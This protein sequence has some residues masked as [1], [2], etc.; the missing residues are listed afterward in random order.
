LTSVSCLC[1]VLNLTAKGKTINQKFLSL[2]LNT[3]LCNLITGNISDQKIVPLAFMI[4]ANM[5]T[6]DLADQIFEDCCLDMMKLVHETTL[7]KIRKDTKF[8]PKDKIFTKFFYLITFCRFNLN[9]LL[10]ENFIEKVQKKIPH[11]KYFEVFLEIFLNVD[12]EQN[13]LIVVSGRIVYY[14]IVKRVELYEILLKK[15]QFFKRII[16]ILSG[17]EYDL[18]MKGKLGL[19]E[20]MQI[21]KN[22]LGQYLGLTLLGNSR[23]MDGVAVAKTKSKSVERNDETSV[24]NFRS[25]SNE[26][27]ADVVENLREGIQSTIRDGERKN[28]LSSKTGLGAP[29]MSNSQSRMIAFLLMRY[30]SK[31]EKGGGVFFMY[32]GL[33]HLI[34][35]IYRLFKISR[36]SDEEKENIILFYA[37]IIYSK[38]IQDKIRHLLPNLIST[39]QKSFTSN[40]SDRLLIS[41]IQFF[42]HLS[43][44][45]SLH[46]QIA[47]VEFLKN[48]RVI[49]FRTPV[50]PNLRLIIQLLLSN[51]SFSAKTHD[52]ILH[53][54]C[55]RIFEDI[56]ETNEQFRQ[57]TNISKL[58]LAMNFKTFSMLEN[59]PG[60]LTSLPLITHVN[61]VAQIRLYLAALKY[62]IKDGTPF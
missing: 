39:F 35:Y 12:L 42:L 36:I 51:L 54:E 30:I 8:N 34:L 9:C 52:V 28:T 44:N 27:P 61:P 20:D 53:S 15:E 45:S 26:R 62:L 56:D 10:Q 3:Y 38:Q 31:K 37:N 46:S 23:V 11:D 19:F 2:G 55:T 32:R 5:L 16:Q 59:E 29:Q 6:H 40:N 4:L 49:Y 13:N 21:D 60:I 1:V 41:T 7:Q 43:R 58:N 50:N 33:D 22:T 47:E 57:F 17:K 14:L 24:E 48:I 18:V 25:E